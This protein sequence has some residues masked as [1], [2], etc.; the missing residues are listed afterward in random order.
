MSDTDRLVSLTELGGWGFPV[1]VRP[2]AVTSV[3]EL[4]AI[5]PPTYEQW[6]SSPEYE[7]WASS[8]EPYVL[9]LRFEPYTKITLESGVVIR[10]RETLAQVRAAF[11]ESSECPNCGY[12]GMSADPFGGESCTNCGYRDR[13]AT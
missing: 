11:G 2:A 9:P 6:V 7:Q 13:W 12:R 5:R 8:P 10:V 4:Q 3:S 1:M